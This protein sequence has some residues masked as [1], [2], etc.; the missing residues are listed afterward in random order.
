MITDDIFTQVRFMDSDGHCYGRIEESE[1]DDK[2]F[3]FI[4]T[5]INEIDPNMFIE[6]NRII[7]LLNQD[8]KRGEQ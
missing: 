6:A 5:N 8:M 2:T 4:P 3:V 1:F 7:D